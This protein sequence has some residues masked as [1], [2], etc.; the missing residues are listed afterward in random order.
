MKLITSTYKKLC[1]IE[2]ACCH[3]SH[4]TR[5]TLD[6]D[7]ELYFNWIEQKYLI[8]DKIKNWFDFKFKTNSFI[9]G[10]KRFSN[11]ILLKTNQLI[12]LKNTL[13]LYINS[14]PIKNYNKEIISCQQT[15]YTGLSF[16]KVEYNIN[17]IF[18]SEEIILYQEDDET[19]DYVLGYHLN[20]LEQAKYALRSHTN[21]FYN[22]CWE[23]SLEGDKPGQFL[24]SIANEINER[25]N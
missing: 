12:E 5:L 10:D 2:C 17:I 16:R 11:G 19:G 8:K 13:A 9:S 15:I 4:I 23:A 3:E 21:K 18:D 20:D 22:G 1:E 6:N 14:I 7:G 25:T 24:W